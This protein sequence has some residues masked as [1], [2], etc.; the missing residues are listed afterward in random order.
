MS[1]FYQSTK[2]LSTFFVEEESENMP[3]SFSDIIYIN[4]REFKISDVSFV[5]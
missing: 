2:G 4:L 1:A 5:E 3:F